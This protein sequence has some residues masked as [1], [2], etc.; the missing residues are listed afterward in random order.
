MTCKYAYLLIFDILEIHKVWN[1]FIFEQIKC[2]Y[3]ITQGTK[4]LNE[5]SD[6]KIHSLMM[7]MCVHLK[8]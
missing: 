7:N 2:Y 6:L 1:E 3:Y 5:F 8:N 4:L